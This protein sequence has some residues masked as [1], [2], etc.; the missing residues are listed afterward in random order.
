MVD[1]RQPLWEI[2]NSKLIKPP[3][4]RPSSYYQLSEVKTLISSGK[5]RLGDNALTEARKAFGWSSEDIFAALARLKPSHFY[6]SD[7]SIYDP[8]IVLDFYKARGLM[9]ENVYTHFY[10]NDHSEELVINS[11]KEI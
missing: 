8:K 3:K 10:I 11:F 7:K 6:K 2:M 1:I 4:E 9:G 5:V